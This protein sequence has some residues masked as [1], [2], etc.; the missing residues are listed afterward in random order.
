MVVPAPPK[1]KPQLVEFAIAVGNYPT[2]DMANAE[3]DYLS[4]LVPL[5][6]R[7]SR[8]KGGSPGCQLLLGHFD[9]AEGAQYY[10]ERLQSRGLI[11][12]AR[13]IET[14]LPSTSDSDGR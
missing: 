12:D 8:L 4:R 1:P 9:S 13:V 6:V 5:R 7:V 11:P 10:V 2:R 14:P 3:R